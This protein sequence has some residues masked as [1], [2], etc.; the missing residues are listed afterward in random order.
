MKKILLATIT[1]AAILGAS[2]AIAGIARQAEDPG[3]LLRAAIEKEEV[4][5][6]LQG[7]IALYKQIVAKYSDQSAVAAK[8][9]LRI[10]MC[11]EKLGNVEAVKAYEAVLSRFPKEAE[12]VA[13]ARVRLA[14]LRKEEPLGLAVTRLLTPG[15]ELEGQ[16]LSPDGTKM[17]GFIMNR[18]GQNL[19]VYDLATAKTEMLTHYEWSKD[20]CATFM[21]AWS[22]D[23][24]EI[25]HWTGCPGGPDQV[26]MQLRI[27]G[28]D[29]RSRILFRNADRGVAP[30]VWTPDKSAVAAVVGKSDGSYGLSLIS[31]QDGA[32]RELCPLQRTFRRNDLQLYE[33]STSA[34]VSPDGRFIVF[35]DGPSGGTRDIFVVSSQGGSPLI[36]TDHPSDDKA[37]RWSPDGRHIVFLSLRHGSWALWGVAVK[38]GKPDGQPFMLLE[39]MQNADLASWTKRGLVSR[40]MAFLRDLYTVEIDP[41]RHE[42]QGK[43]QVVNFSPSGTNSCAAW[44]PDGRHLAFVSHS[45]DQPSEG[46]VAVLPAEG[47]PVRTYRIPT[48]RLQ[49]ASLH[50]LR[51]LPDSSGLGFSHWDNENSY[52]LFRLELSSGEWKTWPIPDTYFTSVEWGGDGKTIFYVK[53]MGSSMELDLVERNLENGQERYILH[54][55]QWRSPGTWSM[56]ASRDYRKL[57]RASEDGKIELI[58]KATGKVVKLEWEKEK[59][60]RPA[61]SPDGKYLVAPW[62]IMD[63]TESTDLFI[64]SVSDGKLKSLNIDRYLRSG[65]R[66]AYPDWSPDGKRIAFHTR[67]WKSET[68]LI[69]NLI[70]KK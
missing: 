13:E 25:V 29:G 32:C 6:D 54:D 62:S 8:A 52:S 15:M 20:A 26:S 34:D 43:P 23:S 11:Y 14:A 40:I 5:G 44:S 33:A 57:A 56:K 3:V 9:Q 70:T 38:E 59:L 22:P 60:G 18:E 41:E 55:E 61:W 7:A 16:T 53:R 24:K 63:E 19:A 37:A 27:T 58:D 4:D 30:C 39:G 2:A 51:W 45:V 65:E 68:N 69:T 21:A 49:S 17:A 28:L 66:I 64:V 50:D 31:T 10:G 67:T 12:A 46:Y 42:L 36:L 35:S 47:G 48:S 1:L